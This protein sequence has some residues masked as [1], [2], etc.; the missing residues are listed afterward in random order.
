MLAQWKLD[1][2]EGPRDR[3]FV[4]SRFVFTYCITVYLVVRGVGGISFVIPR[5]SLL[6]GS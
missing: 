2:T 3:G 1:I 5:T 6:R 4:I